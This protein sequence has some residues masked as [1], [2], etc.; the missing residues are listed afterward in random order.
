GVLLVLASAYWFWFRDS[1][2]ARVHQVYVTGVDGPQARAIRSALE[3]AGLEQSS[4][5]VRTDALKAAVQDYPVVRS[6]SAQGEFPHK[7][8]IQVDLNLPVGVLSGP[9]GRV[10]VSADGL[11]LPD[12]PITSN[13]P[14][15]AVK[16]A[17][18][19]K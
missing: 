10:P 17:L 13:L 9:S 15:L 18:P 14:I 1:S 19:D 3:D 4:L 2:F 7:L 8:Q 6:V 5:H 11:L 12:V 16:V